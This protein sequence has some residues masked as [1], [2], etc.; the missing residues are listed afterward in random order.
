MLMEKCLSKL[1]HKYYKFII[2]LSYE[3]DWRDDKANGY[4]IL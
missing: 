2:N 3:G 1:I 4:G